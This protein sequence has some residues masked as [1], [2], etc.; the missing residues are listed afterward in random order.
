MVAI[1]NYEELCA[2]LADAVD[3]GIDP[4]CKNAAGSLRHQKEH[5][6]GPRGVYASGMV[7]TP[8]DILNCGK[9][10]KTRRRETL[11]SANAGEE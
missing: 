3:E 7:G 6:L 11:L 10:L 1:E 8:L 2:W 9:K 4:L 5:S